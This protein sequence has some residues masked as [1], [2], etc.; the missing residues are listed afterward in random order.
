MGLPISMCD[1][2]RV[3]LLCWYFATV[4]LRYE[5]AARV[6]GKAKS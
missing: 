1:P 2:R 6:K 5:L 3:S 4:D